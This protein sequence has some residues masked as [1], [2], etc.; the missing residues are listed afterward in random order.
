M[1]SLIG[2]ALNEQLLIAEKT[3]WLHLTI[4]GKGL[5]SI[6]FLFVNSLFTDFEEKQFYRSSWQQY[7]ARDQWQ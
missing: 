4:L 5:V 7:L 6:H 2:C 3:S 1:I